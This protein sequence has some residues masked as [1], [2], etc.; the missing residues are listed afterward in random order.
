ME[1]NKALE[2][3]K[4]AL[5]DF[6]YIH[7][8]YGPCQSHDYDDERLMKLLKNPCNRM[9]LEILIEYIQEYFEL[10]YYDMDNLVRLP[11]ND[12]VLNNIKERWDL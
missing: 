8:T 10:G 3:R 1:K 12:E 7:S 11:D 5:K 2:L 6:N 4:Q 9:A